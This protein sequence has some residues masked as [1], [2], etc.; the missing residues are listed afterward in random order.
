MEMDRLVTDMVQ[1]G[2]LVTFVVCCLLIVRGL[3]HERRQ[4][5]E[6]WQPEP[7]PAGRARLRLIHGGADTAEVYDWAKDDIG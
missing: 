4:E 1:I 2:L 5:E 7:H 3:R 6:S